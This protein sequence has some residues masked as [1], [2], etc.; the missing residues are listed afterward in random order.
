M[1][2][3]ATDPFSTTPKTTRQAFYDREKELTM[4]KRAVGEGRRLVLVLGVRRTG[5]TSL[6]KV[7]LNELRKP[8][9]FLDL[10]AL[11]SY[12]D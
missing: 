4:I 11:D 9:L 12:E 10:R 3:L 2:S 7:A 5:K 6:I 1:R 8:Y